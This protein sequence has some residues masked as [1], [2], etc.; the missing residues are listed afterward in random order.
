MQF[1]ILHGKGGLLGVALATALFSYLGGLVMFISIKMRTGSYRRLFTY[2]LGTKF[3][4]LMDGLSLFIL[5]GGLGVMM[6]GSAAVFSEQFA[7]PSGSG[8]FIIAAL[9][10]LVILGG[11]KR[12]LAAYVFLVPLKL[13]AVAFISLAALWASGGMAG[14]FLPA[15]SGGGVAGNWALAGLLYVSYNMVVPVAVLSSMGRSVP[16]KLG[17]AG[18]VLGGLLL[19]LAV[20]LVTLAGMAYLPEAATYQIP[21]MY[22]A[23]SLGEV[24]RWGLGLLIWLAILTTAIAN[25]HGFASRLAPEG[26]KSY[27]IFG[28]GACLLALPLSCCSFTVLVRFLYPLFGYAGML[29]LITLLL[30]PLKIFSIRIK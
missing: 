28:V 27:R 13:A 25:A 6:A 11:L 17:V 9:T 19:G 15:Q 22:L 16:L 18:G 20:L 4:M 14:P 29:L 7:F 8:V 30:K 21:L 5:L 24:F 10:S 3:G 26:G 1:F 2:L 23:G 12:V